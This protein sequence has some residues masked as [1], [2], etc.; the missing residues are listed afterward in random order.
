MAYL[1]FYL[2]LEAEAAAETMSTEVKEN[3]EAAAVA[4]AEPLLSTLT[5]KQLM[6][7]LRT[8]TYTYHLAVVAPA[9]KA[10]TDFPPEAPEELLLQS[11]KVAL[12]R[13]CIRLHVAAAKV[14]PAIPETLQLI[15]PAAQAAVFGSVTTIHIQPF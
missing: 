7:I 3:R 12:V 9:A 10:G 15:Q 1:S 6:I 13:H 11:L 2:A 14:A 5:L 8:A 4:A